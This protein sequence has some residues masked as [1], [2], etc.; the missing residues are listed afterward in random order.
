[1]LRMLRKLDPMPVGLYLYTVYFTPYLLK[2]MF[3]IYVTYKITKAL[4]KPY[5]QKMPI[6]RF[7]IFLKNNNKI[8]SVNKRTVLKTKNSP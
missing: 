4:N 1:M 5:E 7:S 8:L 3:S 6:I 2:L